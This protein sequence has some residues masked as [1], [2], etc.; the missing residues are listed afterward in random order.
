MTMTLKEIG[1]SISEHL[2]KDTIHYVWNNVFPEEKLEEHLNKDTI[3]DLKEEL[4]EFFSHTINVNK[5]M[6]TYNYLLE[7]DLEEI[8]VNVYAD[9]FN[10]D[11]EE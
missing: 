11:F 4:M 6:E 7:E 1:N 3:E 2:T 9:S 5:M 8:N 10:D